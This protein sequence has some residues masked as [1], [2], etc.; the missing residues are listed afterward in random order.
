MQNFKKIIKNEI[1]DIKKNENSINSLKKIKESFLNVAN[2]KKINNFRLLN[3]I[4]NHLH[5]K[6]RFDEKFGES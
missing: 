5:N 3:E 1:E 2:E 4:N 6:M